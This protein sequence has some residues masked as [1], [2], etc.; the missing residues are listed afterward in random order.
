MGIV[1]LGTNVVT[2]VA[3]LTLND[4]HLIEL[5]VGEITLVLSDRAKGYL[6]LLG[7]QLGFTDICFI[8][9]NSGARTLL[10]S[11]TRF[12]VK[13]KGRPEEFNRKFKEGFI[14]RVNQSLLEHQIP[15]K[16]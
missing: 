1:G 9:G 12:R 5:Q 8:K 2:E 16:A 10:E 15:A 14:K 7:I 4:I 6:Y 3:T 11:F 13:T